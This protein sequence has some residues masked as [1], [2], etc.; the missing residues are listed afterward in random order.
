ML[1]QVITAMATPFDDKGEINLNEAKRLA[2]YLLENG[3]DAVLAAGTTGESPTLTHLEK[4]ELVKSLKAEFGD[5]LTLIAGA[6]TNDTH[7]SIELAKEM[8][9]L[10]ADALLVV[11]PYYNKPPQEGL[12]RHFAAVAG[13]VKLPVIIYNIPG[14]TG[15]NL[16]PS[17][18]AK[19]LPIP[20]LLAVKECSNSLTQ[21]T[22]FLM[23]IE[24]AGRGKTAPKNRRFYLYSGE[25]PLTLPLLSLGGE[26]VI[27]V[28]SH[29]GGKEFQ[30]MF[31]AYREGR[32]EEAER[33]HFKLYP[34]IQALFMTTSPIMIKAALELKGFK[35]GHLR[36]PL[37]DA[38]P[39][40]IAIMKKVL[41]DFER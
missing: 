14:R 19:L 5:R 38:D 22:E 17:T 6:G 25:D 34:L 8:E 28:A 32:V 27:S 37:L 2:A 7:G 26:G 29:L 13:A 16:L 30:T 24:K 3:T 10:G 1:G 31:R 11:S 4:L 35:M 33:M 9:S 20:N 15:V 23:E 12:L 40:Q 39:A 18:L 36:A 41:A 21:A